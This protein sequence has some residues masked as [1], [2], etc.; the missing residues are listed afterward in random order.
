[1]IHGLGG[2]PNGPFQL[3]NFPI[4]KE[5]TWRSQGPH[6]AATGTISEAS[7]DVLDMVMAFEIYIGVD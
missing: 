7:W 1:L 5:K 6:F 3:I 2:F 4:D